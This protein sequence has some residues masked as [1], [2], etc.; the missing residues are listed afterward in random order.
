MEVTTI[1]NVPTKKQERKKESDSTD[2]S[3]VYNMKS[4]PK[5][6][7]WLTKMPK[8][9]KNQPETKIFQKSLFTFKRIQ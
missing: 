6:Y 1:R 2:I 8:F 7:F 3:F 4:D 9:I 5:G